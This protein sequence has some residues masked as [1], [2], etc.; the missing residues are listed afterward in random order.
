MLKFTR[1]D[2]DI[3]WT[4]LQNKGVTCMLLTGTIYNADI[5]CYN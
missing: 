2:R 1:S 3:H 4:E 5:E